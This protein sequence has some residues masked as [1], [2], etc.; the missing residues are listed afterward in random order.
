[1]TMVFRYAPLGWGRMLYCNQTPFL[2]CEGEV[3]ARDYLEFGNSY[4]TTSA[5]TKLFR[6]DLCQNNDTQKPFNLCNNF[7][8]FCNKFKATRPVTRP[9]SLLQA[10]SCRTCH[11]DILYSTKFSRDKIFADRPLTNFCGNKLHGSRIPVSHTQFR[12]PLNTLFTH[13]RSN[14]MLGCSLRA[15]GWT[16][17][18]AFLVCSF[19]L[20]NYV[21]Q[22]GD[23]SPLTNAT[24]AVKETYDGG[25]Q[26]YVALDVHV[27]LQKWNSYHFVSTDSWE[28]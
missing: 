12:R 7:M 20:I 6:K 8:H 25:P 23:A 16:S 26:C 18:R 27:I 3:W 21:S 24:S 22:V 10:A 9:V 17:S 19:E 15:F 2:L 13:S 1:M 28:I 5:K 4:F 11:V 14:A